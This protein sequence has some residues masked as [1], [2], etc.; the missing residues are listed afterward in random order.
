MD[1]E[2]LR[3]LRKANRHKQEDLARELGYSVSLVRKWEQ[4]KASPTL[5]TLKKICALYNVSSD[6]LLGLSRD[7]TSRRQQTPLSK[8]R[9]DMLKRF[10]AFLITEE[11]RDKK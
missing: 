7:Y 9:Q 11:K 6:Y 4:G 8:E 10:E 1:G 5:E 2:R 3:E